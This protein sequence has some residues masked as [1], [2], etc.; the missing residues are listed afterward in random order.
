MIFIAVS[1]GWFRILV[2]LWVSTYFPYLGNCVAEVAEDEVEKI[3]NQLPESYTKRFGEIVWA[4]GGA[5]Y[6][7]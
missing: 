3:V 5:G 7:W 6:G 2:K 4:Q 1:Y